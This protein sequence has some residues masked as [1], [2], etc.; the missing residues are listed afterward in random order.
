MRLRSHGFH[1]GRSAARTVPF[2][3]AVG[4]LAMALSASSAA[5]Q[6]RASAQHDTAKKADYSA[7]A[8]APYTA[9]NVSVPTPRG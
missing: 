3:L 1:P 8:G 7:P 4:A 9:V 6:S 5:A 2:A